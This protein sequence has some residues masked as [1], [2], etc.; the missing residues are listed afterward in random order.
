MSSAARPPRDSPVQGLIGTYFNLTAAQD[1]IQPADPSNPAWLGNQTPA[2]TAQL[3]GPIDFPDIADNGFADSVGDPAY[4]NLGAGNN[5]N[6]EARWY[7]D[8]M[9]PGTGTAPVPIN[10]ATTSDDGSMLYIDG[11]AVVN[12]NNFQGATQATGLADLTPGLHT[13]DVEYYQGGGGA[14]MDVQ[15]D[16]TGGTNFVD[17]PNSAFSSIEAVN[18]LIND[19]HRHVDPVE[20]QHLFR[21]NHDQRRHPGRD[22]EWRH[23][24]GH[25]HGHRRQYRR[26]PGLYRRP[27]LHHRGTDHHQR[28]RSGRQRR[29][30]EYQRHEHLCRPHHPVRGGDDWLRC[31]HA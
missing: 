21:V 26:R 20:N 6:V 19:G 30:R 14:T 18:G 8:I 3:V 23:G 4:Y 2:V 10:F 16:P 22:G 24:T 28:L 11:N 7:G 1:L 12:N 9:I 15:W 5:N 25:G 27:Q 29:H 13:I 31:R 17:I